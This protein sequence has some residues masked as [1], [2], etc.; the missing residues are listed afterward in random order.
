MDRKSSSISHPTTGAIPVVFIAGAPRSGSTLLDRVIGMQQGFFSVGETHFVWE[1]SFGENHLCG[2]GQPFHDCPF[3]SEV[4]QK[5]FGI[6]IPEVD[7]KAVM[8]LKASVDSK[9]SLPWLILPKRP[10]RKEA[11]LT[12]Y[13]EMLEKLYGAVLEV[14]GKSVIVDSSKDPRHGLILS[15]LPGFELHVVHLVRDPRAVAFSWRRRKRRPEIH[16]EAQNMPTEGIAT[17]AKRWATHNLLVESLRLSAD[18]CCRIRYED[19]VTEPQKVLSRALS[20]FP[21]IASDALIDSDMAV[22]LEPT[23]TV[24]GNPMRFKHGR[25]KLKL[26]AEWRDEMTRRD[27]SVVTAITGPLMLR[28]G[29]GRRTQAEARDQGQ[30]G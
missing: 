29:Y 28:Y 20:P 4:S 23:H 18:S 24:S 14:S 27:R 19:L 22:E 21:S 9:R 2:C 17:T 12:R 16:W 11:E 5:A 26:D 10:A 25:I 30:S 13:G 8:R 3:W 6:D 7:E 1:R 15:R